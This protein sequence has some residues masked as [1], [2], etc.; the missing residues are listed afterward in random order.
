MYAVEVGNALAKAFHDEINADT[1]PDGRMYYNIASRVIPP[2][3]RRC[4]E[5]V[6][7]YAQA[8]YKGMNERAG[9]GLKAQRAK[10]NEDRVK[11]LVEYACGTEDYASRQKNFE[12]SLVNYSQSVATDTMK[13][14]AD[15]QY[16][17]GL[18][19]VI[20]RRGSSDCCGWCKALIKDYPYE[21]VKATGSAVYRRHRDCRCQVYYDPGDGKVQ[22]VHTKRWEDKQVILK[23]RTIPDDYNVIKDYRRIMR[24]NKGGFLVDPDYKVELHEEEIEFANWIYK[25]FGGELRC[26]NEKDDDGVLN[27]DY[28]WNGALWDLKTPTTSKKDTLDKR[29]RHGLEQIESNPGGLMIDFSNSKL[30]LED[31]RDM[32]ISILEKKARITTDVIVK[33]GKAFEVIRVKK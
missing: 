4:Y 8:M 12:G 28:M 15:F 30:G 24:P 19:P 11:G 31:G 10:Y 6:A 7:D 13:E 18:S 22:N 5:D 2:P 1:L 29:I 17:A 27:P 14:N 16:Q 20:K 3:L 32:V 26:L 23:D 33:K 9:L 21:T 25:T